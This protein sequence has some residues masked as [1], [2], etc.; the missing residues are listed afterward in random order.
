MECPCNKKC[1]NYERC[2][3]YNYKRGCKE[4]EEYIK[5]KNKKN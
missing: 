5:Q 3:L 2:Q 4:Y 1:P